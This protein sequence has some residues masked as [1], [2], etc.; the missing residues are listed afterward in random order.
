MEQQNKPGLTEEEK[1]ARLG[2]FTGSCAIKL[3][4][5][6]IT[7]KDRKAGKLSK[8]LQSYIIENLGEENTGTAEYFSSRHTDYGLQFEAEGIEAVERAYRITVEPATFVPHYKYPEEAGCT[9]DGNMLKN[10]QL[11]MKNPDKVLNHFRYLL[12]NNWLDLKRNYPEVY[13]QQQYNLLCARKKWSLFASY[14]RYASPQLQLKTIVVP[15]N[16]KDQELLEERLEAA[17]DYKNILKLQMSRGHIAPLPD[18]YQPVER[19]EENSGA[20]ANWE[21]L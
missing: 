12:L 17:I 20:L 4:T 21:N 1:K 9:P 14:C 16:A 15:A 18:P 19:P 11:E 5:D 2:K 7:V 10:G 8:T 6:P 3:I 13:W